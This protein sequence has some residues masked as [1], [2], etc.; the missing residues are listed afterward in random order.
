ML[1][2][3]SSKQITGLLDFDFATV[4]HP[5]HDFFTGLWDV[6]GGVAM[7]QNCDRFLRAPVLSTEF[8]PVPE[9]LSDDIR[10]KWELARVWDA[11]LVKK[12]A[13][14]PSTIAGIERLDDLRTMVDLLCPRALSNEM[15]LSKTPRE[16][17]ERKRAENEALIVQLLE[18][19]GF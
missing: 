5:C 4:N 12:G 17:Q 19:Y 13:L 11:E 3:N 18:H 7:R 1:F 6:G 8:D 16:V 9:D 10:T 2:D 15:M 14:R